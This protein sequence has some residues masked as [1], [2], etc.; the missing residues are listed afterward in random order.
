ML[1][2]KVL[3]PLTAVVAELPDDDHLILRFP[4][5]SVVEGQPRAGDAIQARFYGRLRDDV[6]VD[7]PFSEALSRYLERPVALVRATGP[8]GAVDR[9]R[10]G[11]V[12]L[13]SR[14]S[15]ERLAGA[16]EV[17]SV[18]VRR[19]R[20]TI[21]IDG[22]DA[23]EEDAWVGRRVRLGA[24]VVRFHGHV[25]RCLITSRDPET[26]VIDLP[27]L[28]ALGAYRGNVTGTEPLPFGIYGEVLTPG[29]VRVGDPVAV[30]DD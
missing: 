3:G 20:M 4:D 9:G 10:R 7:G 24:A 28:D 8:A 17:D 19:F 6:R 5:G 1:N 26:G 29:P 11:G 21:E 2:G 25:G 23:H 22:V 15:L 18:D 27:T 12:S 13:I 30:P 14:A 16:A